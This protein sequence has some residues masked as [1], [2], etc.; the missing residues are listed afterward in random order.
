MKVSR[1]WLQKY[2]SAPLPSVERLAEAFTFNAFEVEGHNEDMIDLKVLPDR[3][4]YALSHRGVASELA[5]ILDI[6]LKRDPLRDPLPQWSSTDELIIEADPTYVVRHTGAIVRGV[7]VGVSPTW[8]SEALES[9]GQRSINNVVDIL[10]YVTL[11]L[12]QPAGAFDIGKMND[13]GGKVHVDIRKA[14]K[15]EKITVLTGEEYALDDTMYVFAQG[16]HLLDIAGIKGGKSSGVTDTT[17]DLFISVGNYDGTLIRKTSQALKLF[18]DASQ[19]FQN[20]PSP[21]L[22]ACG[23]REILAL[24]ADIAGGTLVGV[25]DYY[26]K[27]VLPYKVGV[28][29]TEVN[30]LLGTQFSDHDIAHALERLSVLNETVD[31]VPRMLELAHSVVGKPYHLGAS[32]LRDAPERFD[33]SSFTAWL[34][35]EVGIAAPRVSVDQYLW[36]E[37]IEE[38]D[39]APGDLIFYNTTLGHVWYESKE[40]LPGHAVPQGVDH[41]A[42][43][44]GDGELVDASSAVGGVK[45]EKIDGYRW[46]D[47]IVAYGRP[48]GAGEKR[49][50]VTVP[51]ERTDL[52]IKEDLIEEVGRIIGYDKVEPLELPIPATPPDQARF[53][54]IERVKDMLVAEG[55]IEVSTQTFAK[56]GDIKLAN[57][58]DVEKPFLRTNLKDNLK[59]AHA[60]ADYVAPLLGLT[61][62]KLFEVGTV[63]P[64]SGEILEVETSTSAQTPEITDDPAY[65]PKRYV[66]GTYQPISIYPFLLRDIAVWVPGSVTATEVL[67]LI[68]TVTGKSCVRTGLFDTFTKGER[69]SYAFHLVFQSFEKTLADSDVNPIM[70]KVGTEMTARGWEVR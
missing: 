20:R 7:T 32:V 52:R 6:P 23:M 21:E 51:F 8:L 29:T 55:F 65:E 15:G 34:L 53:R 10:N 24:I 49:F 3:A 62:P 67:R 36:V 41:V 5:A 33:C 56:V 48:R 40:Y 19:R 60:R 42:L 25:V 57:P 70:E 64:K 4:G 38:K 61:K 45:V 17:T 43:F 28:S 47:K 13:A 58:L 66:L 9:V 30:T 14:K 12:G 37:P 50:V 11:D 16:D 69:T 59:D 39:L 68:E 46:A 1:T 18:T 35:K 27:P 31:P 44:L 2:F 63:F 54:G 26:P 22:T